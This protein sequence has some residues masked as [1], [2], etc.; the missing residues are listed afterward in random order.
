M[1]LN[2]L[3]LREASFYCSNVVLMSRVIA[4]YLQWDINTIIDEIT[5]QIAAL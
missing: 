4:C 5:Q 3:P 2:F 1:E